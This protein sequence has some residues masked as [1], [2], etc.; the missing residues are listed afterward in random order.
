MHT[1]ISAWQKSQDE[2]KKQ[3]KQKTKNKKTKE[4]GWGGGGGGGGRG[5]RNIPVLEIILLIPV[6]R[7]D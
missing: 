5:V 3:N 4:K 1:S 7:I 2:T 6:L